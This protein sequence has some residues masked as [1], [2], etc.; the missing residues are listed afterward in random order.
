MTT[1]R[2]LVVSL[3]LVGSL[4]AIPVVTATPASNQAEPSAV[5]TEP[6]AVATEPSV[7]TA[8][9]STLAGDDE[10]RLT[11]TLDRTPEEV[12]TITATLQV[13]I[14][15]QFT[16]LEVEL[17]RGITVTDTNGFS[18]NSDGTAVW[19][20]QTNPATVTYQFEA[21]AQ[22]AD[23]RPEVDGSYR[24]A[25]TE[26]WALIEIPSVGDINGRITSESQPDI[27]RQMAVDGAGVA[28]EHIAFLGAYTERRNHAHGQTFRLIIP[29]EAD[30]VADPDDIFTSLDH[31]ADRLRVGEADSEVVMIAAP[32]GEVEWAV[33]GLQ[34]G[35]RDFWV[36]DD[37]AVDTAANNWVHEYVHTRQKYDAEA[38]FDWFTEATATYY[39]ALFTL[40]EDRINFERFQRYLETGGDDPQA[41]AVLADP[42]SW[43]NFA[44]YRK[45]ALVAGEID[46]D[47][48]V[49]TDGEASLESVFRAVNAH[50][51]PIDARSFEAAVANAAGD[52]AAATATQYT[53][54]EAVPQ[55]WDGSAHATAFGQQPAQFTY[56]FAEDNP[57]TVDGNSVSP[58][59][60][61]LT[62]TTNDRMTVR[63]T[64]ENVGETVG[65]YELPF[66]VGETEETKTGELR[67][68]E[69]ATHEF[70]HQFTETGSYQLTAG[71]ERLSVS[72]EP[73]SEIA[74]PTEIEVPGFTVV[75]AVIAVLVAALVARRWE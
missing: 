73:E 1:W 42:E 30:L 67:P 5:A 70:T 48:R 38:D 19:D 57:I 24:F 23:D 12:G 29:D 37:E 74:L 49:A 65:S 39:A 36:Q 32:T 26:E 55:M 35:D 53:R 7:F 59:N 52:D 11:T 20:E 43:E 33:R 68:G 4:C 62:L 71:D 15:D 44:Q 9:P 10:L 34:V 17:P 6:S 56:R 47:I 14:P 2:V 66:G 51:Q 58:T 27:E 72:V 69:T 8:E 61:N 3:L 28:G 21:D 45:G 60:G 46:R 63:I 54:T 64:V 25:E 40:E 13:D 75:P 31:A 50:S 22:T 16:E 41:S 18:V